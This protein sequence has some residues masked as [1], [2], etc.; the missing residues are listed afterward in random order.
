MSGNVMMLFGEISGRYTRHANVSG[1]G[2]SISHKPRR[3]TS[4]HLTAK[5]M[6]LLCRFMPACMRVDDPRFQKQQIIRN[7]PMAV[8]PRPNPCARWMLPAIIHPATNR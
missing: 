3:L 1:T 2:R 7:A 6:H 4:M 5:I 8:M